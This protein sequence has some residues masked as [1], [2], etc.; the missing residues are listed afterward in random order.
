VR[1]PDRRQPRCE[2]A[3]ARLISKSGIQRAALTALDPLSTQRL[4]DHVALPE[5][6]LLERLQ[7]AS[8][9]QSQPVVPHPVVK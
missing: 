6:L 1:I 8:T 3:T 7:W 4:D 2:R 9:A 5:S